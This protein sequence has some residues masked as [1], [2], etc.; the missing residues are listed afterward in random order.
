M[1]RKSF[2]QR[3]I[4]WVVAFF[5]VPRFWSYSK[6]KTRD[7][8]IKGTR[9]H[10]PPGKSTIVSCDDPWQAVLLNDDGTPNMAYLPPVTVL[11][12]NS[13]GCSYSNPTK[14]KERISN[15]VRSYFLNS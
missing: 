6:E 10:E 11:D 13:Y 9:Y 1:N 12:G 4:T 7:R 8:F 5:S 15:N 2:L 14:L 3:L